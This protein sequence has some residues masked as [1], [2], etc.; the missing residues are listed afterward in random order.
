LTEKI[1]N[2][3]SQWLTYKATP[4]SSGSRERFEVTSSDNNALFAAIATRYDLLNH[5]LSLNIDRRWRKELVRC[6]GAKPKDRILD[7]CT[8]TGDVAIRLAQEDEVGDIVG[9]DLSDE[10]LRI[11]RRKT[12]KNGLGK[13]ITLLRADALHL[14]FEDNRFDT[15][16]IAFGLRN[17]GHHQRGITEMVRVLKKGGQLLILEFSPPGSDLFGV[18]CRL[19]LRTIIPAAGGIMSGSS[20]AYRYLSSSIAAFPGPDEITKLME[21]GGLKKLQTQRLTRGIAY[22]YRGEK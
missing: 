21:T 15:V 20:R 6:A 7:L 3:A 2:Q 14:P 4:R 13:R 10:M 22:L 5:L 12:R 9:I 16:T 11:A 1:V 17:I 18:C 8:G 19:C